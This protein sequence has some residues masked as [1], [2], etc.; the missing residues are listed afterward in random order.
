M[1][2]RG[3]EGA[4]TKTE[5]GRGGQGNG[6][7]ACQRAVG[8]G[9]D[10]AEGGRRWRVE[11]DGLWQRAGK[12]PSPQHGETHKLLTMAGPKAGPGGHRP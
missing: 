11:A 2:M 4:A 9:G 6:D 3:R 12:T 7:R 10:W 5:N 1:G 8:T